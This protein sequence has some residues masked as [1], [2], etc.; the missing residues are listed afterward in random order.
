MLFFA[1]LI[2]FL[3]PSG[4]RH[5]NYAGIPSRVMGSRDPPMPEAAPNDEMWQWMP[6]ICWCLWQAAARKLLLSVAGV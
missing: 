2:T 6:D 1:S 4:E 5:A 3:R